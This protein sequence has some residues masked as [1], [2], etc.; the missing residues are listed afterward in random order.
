MATLSLAMVPKFLGIKGVVLTPIYPIL[1]INLGVIFYF[2][3]L[4]SLRRSIQSKSNVF[5][6]AV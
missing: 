5:Q 2:K 4:P 1:I 6:F 3:S